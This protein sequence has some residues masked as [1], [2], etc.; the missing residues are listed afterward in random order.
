MPEFEG[1]GASSPTER[2]NAASE[3][4]NLVSLLA[5][6]G[7]VSF[8]SQTPDTDPYSQGVLVQK[9]LVDEHEVGELRFSK[10]SR[11]YA[12]LVPFPLIEKK[13]KALQGRARAFAP[14]ERVGLF[15]AEWVKL[16]L[17]YELSQK[18]FKR[19]DG[20]VDV[21]FP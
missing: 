19:G 4:P 8:G 13:M 15:G 17:H 12:G 5:K 1:A 16:R 6:Y 2:F 3:F 7:R 9:V 21:A 18:T 10:N 20:W 11:V 14:P